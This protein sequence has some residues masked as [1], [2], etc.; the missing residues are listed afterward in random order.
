MNYSNNIVQEVSEY[1]QKIINKMNQ[2][3]YSF[4][5]KK[6]N[7]LNK[8]NILFTEIIINYCQDL[9]NKLDA[10]SS[11]FKG[12]SKI[13][14]KASNNII[15]SLAEM[16]FFQS[17]LGYKKSLL[18]ELEG[19][20]Q[21]LSELNSVL[22][23]KFKFTLINIISEI[24]PKY[25]VNDSIIFVDE[26]K[27]SIPCTI[28][29][30]I[31]EGHLYQLKKLTDGRILE[32]NK[33]ELF[34]DIIDFFIKGRENKSNLYSMVKYI[35]RLLSNNEDGFEIKLYLMYT[36]MPVNLLQRKFI[37]DD[38]K[39]YTLNKPVFVWSDSSTFE[40]MKFV[41]ISKTNNMND[42][43]I[44]YNSLYNENLKLPSHT[45]IEIIYEDTVLSWNYKLLFDNSKK[46]IKDNMTKYVK[47]MD[48][49]NSNIYW[50]QLSDIEFQT[51]NDA[52][53]Y[54]YEK[55]MKRNLLKKGDSI[56]LN[57]DILGQNNN[58]ILPYKDA[59]KVLFLTPVTLYSEYYIT[60]GS[61]V[62]NKL[63][64][65][66]GNVLYFDEKTNE[67][68]VEAD[69]KYGASGWMYGIGGAA[70]ATASIALIGTPIVISTLTA[71]TIGGTGLG[72][73]AKKLN[74]KWGNKGYDN[75][76]R[77]FSR[78]SLIWEDYKSIEGYISLE[79]TNCH[80]LTESNL[81]GLLFKYLDKNILENLFFLYPPITN[82][83]ED[84]KIEFDH[85]EKNL[86]LK[87]ETLESIYLQSSN[88]NLSWFKYITSYGSESVTIANI[89]NA[90]TL[91]GFFNAPLS[92]I[93][94]W[95]GLRALTKISEYIGVLKNKKID[96]NKVHYLNVK[97]YFGQD[98]E[99]LIFQCLKYDYRF[100]N[101]PVLLEAIFR[102]N[103]NDDFQIEEKGY[104]ILSF[105]LE[106]NR[107]D[108][109]NQIEVYTIFKSLLSK[110]VSSE[111]VSYFLFDLLNFNNLE[112]YYEEIAKE[113]LRNI[114]NYHFLS[115]NNLV[116]DSTINM[117]L[118]L[119]KY[120]YDYSNY[121][122]NRLQP[123]IDFLEISIPNDDNSFEKYKV[124]KQCIVSDQNNKLYT[125]EK[126][127]IV[128]KKKDSF[129]FLSTDVNDKNYKNNNYFPKKLFVSVIRNLNNSSIVLNIPRNNIEYSLS[130]TD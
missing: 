112:D 47:I 130:E 4:R 16:C 17:D 96:P 19:F 41:N 70:L 28:V 18:K 87:K 63:T 103:I 5:L 53:F 38:S 89:A 91:I 15:Q 97:N 127:S 29:K 119:K 49:R 36:V 68:L 65:V 117:N 69:G 1:Y 82:L 7:I 98:L 9:R 93:G 20:Y 50:I 59:D 22:I 43:E 109:E 72:L 61:R 40:K 48:K 26:L 71:T 51:V 24:I 111:Q 129:P 121:K 60:V 90:G 54:S 55:K 106:F 23:S 126:N 10:L 27:Q 37:L 74:K 122:V 67:Y 73:L 35:C 94:I 86:G 88:P 85:L 33:N 66:S 25:N 8:S 14:N 95:G 81:N 42:L 52:Y 100:G 120:L 118:K 116:F 102:N 46:K 58:I 115:V 39:Y 64:G 57:N 12:S 30:V 31:K 77:S 34:P 110:I 104:E 84:E 107:V 92:T 62:S 128:L 108:P 83:R 32:K 11:E 101:T 6:K 123:M 56:I 2:D 75:I 78:E 21:L 113:Y 13:K 45:E 114:C 3:D 99:K 80:M 76:V 105:F 125:I 79:D 124:I 44:N